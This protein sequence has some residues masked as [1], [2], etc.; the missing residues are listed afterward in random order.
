M[1]YAAIVTRYI[2]T[3]PRELIEILVTV[4]DIIH[5][6]VPGTNE[7]LKWGFPVFQIKSKDFSYLRYAKKHVTLGFYNFAKITEKKNLLQGSGNTL[8]HIKISNLHDVNKPL[9]TKWLKA[10]SA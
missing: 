2:Q 6:S 1:Q 4:R 10:I 7:F 9:L 8:R 5:E 3:A